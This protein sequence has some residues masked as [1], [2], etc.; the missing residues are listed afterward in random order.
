MFCRADGGCRHIAAALYELNNFVA[1][2][3]SVTDGPCTWSKKSRPSDEPM[4]A[5]DLFLLYR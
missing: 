5:K 4:K 3:A 1:T 2:A